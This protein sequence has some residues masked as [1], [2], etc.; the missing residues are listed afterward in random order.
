[1]KKVHVI[2]FV[3]MFISSTVIITEAGSIGGYPEPKFENCDKS[4]IKAIKDAYKTLTDAINNSSCI[5]EDIRSKLKKKLQGT[6]TINCTSSDCTNT[7]AYTYTNTSEIFLCPGA[8]N[9]NSCGCMEAV[10]LHELIHTVG[11]PEERVPQ[12]CEKSCFPNC[13]VTDPKYTGCCCK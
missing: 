2:L 10:E 5:S 8:Y 1:M 7:C 11:Y 12:E 6:I 13:A 3:I 9:P 4:K